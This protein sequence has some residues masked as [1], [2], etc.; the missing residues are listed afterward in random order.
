MDGE[1]IVAWLDYM[2]ESRYMDYHQHWLHLRRVLKEEYPEL[3]LAWAAK[4]KV[5]GL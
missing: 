5:L 3:W 1:E 2:E 4:R